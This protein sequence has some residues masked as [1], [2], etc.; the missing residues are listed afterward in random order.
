MICVYPANCTDFSTNGLGVVNPQSCIVTETLNGEW[1]L[2]LVHPIDETGKWQ[3]LME[4]CI[5]RAPVPA[6]MTPRVQISLPEH[7]D[8]QEIYVIDTDTSEA[9][10]RGGT[11]RLRVGPGTGYTTL[12]QY[13]NGT[14]LQVIVKTNA[15]WYEVVMPDGK[16][17]FMDTRFLR[18][19]RTEGSYS[20]AINTVVTA[21][22]LRDQPFRIY[23]V[24]PELNKVTIHA[25]HIFYDLLDNMVKKIEPS[26]SMAGAAVVQS[27]SS[28]CLSEHGFT[29]YSNLTST[30]EG[31]CIENVNPVEGILGESGLAQKYHGELAR[32]WFDVFLVDRVGCDSDVQIRERKNLLGVSY[33]IDETDVVTRIMPTGQDA[34]G[35]LLYLPE[36]YIDSPNIGL[37]THPK[38]IHLA[39]SEAKEVTEGD[40]TKSKSEC[41]AEMRKAVQAQYDAG[42]DLPSVTLKVEFINC[43]DTEEYKQ[44]AALTDIFL[45]DSVR[46][47][48]R[49]IGVEVSMRMTQY[50]YDCLVG[51]YTSITLGTVADTLEGATISARQLASGSIT[52]AKLALNSVG[53]GQLQSGS[54]GSL[55]IKNAAISSAHIQTAAITRAHIAQA[56]IETLNVNALT[57]VS[58]KIQELAAG[59]ITTDELYTSIAMIA[60]A[61]LTTANI[62]NAQIEWAQIESLAADIATISKAQI[63]SANIDAA[64]IDWASITTLSAAVASMVKADIETADIDWSH[65]KDLATDTAIITQGTAGELYIAKLAVTEANLVSLTV[66]E[67]VVKGEDGRFY[68]VSIDAEGNV[69]SALKQVSNED[70]ADVSIH[71]TQKLIEGSITA[72]T[73]NVQEIFADN[74]TVRSI[75]A[76]N[77]DVDTLFARE[78]TL[79]AI[80][81]MD[82]TGN[83]YLKLM[84]SGK[85]DQTAVDALGERVSAA[86]L[87]LTEDS[88]VSVVRGSQ[89][90][91]EDL[92]SVQTT[93]SGPEFIV[94]TQT[95]AVA[96]WTG[97]ASFSQLKD[98]QQITYWLPF[99]SSSSVTLELTLPDGSTTG[100]I[101]CYYSQATRITSQ[102]SGGNILHLT[103]REN[104]K[105]LTNTIEKGWWADANYNTDTYDRIR[106][107]SVKV[108]EAF[109]AFRF[110][111]ADSSGYFMLAAGKPFDISK[112]ILWATGTGTAGSVTANV[113]LAYSSIYLRY[114]VSGFTGVQGA[115]CYLAGALDGTMFTPAETYLTCTAPAA[116]DG[117]TY[118]LLGT[119]SS[120]YYLVLYPEHPMYRYVDGAFKP[121]SYVGYEARTEVEN[122]RVET[123]TAIEQT[124][125]SIALKADQTAVD[126]LSERMDSAEIKLQPD[127]IAS[128]VRSSTYYQNDLYHARNYALK[129]NIACKFIG[130]KYHNGSSQTNTVTITYNVS[131]DLFEHSHDG[132]SIRISVD[133]LRSEV[134]AASAS[135]A[136]VYSGMFLYFTYLDDSGAETVSG[137]GWYLRTTD[138][139]FR[140][141][142][143]TW[144]RITKG[145]LNIAAYNAIKINYMGLG[146][147][148]AS[149]STGTVQFRN[150]KL[151]VSNSFTP[152]S[153]APEDLS[154][155]QDRLTTAESSITQHSN[156]IALKV[157][158]S[159]YN[160]NR[161]YRGSTAPTTLYT[162][163]LWLDTSVSPNLLKRYT[164]STWVVAG[165][166]EV[167]SSGL[168]IGSNNVSI[169][170]ENFLLQLLDP[171]NNENV[172]MEMSA[173]GNVGF[174]ELYA[175]DIV[176]KSVVTAYNGPAYLYVD[177]TY[178][179]TDE[180]YCRTFNDAIK[181]INYK[182][183][184][185]DIAILFMGSE[186]ELYEVSGVQIVGICGHGQVIISGSGGYRLNTYMTIFGCSVPINFQT[187]SIR[188]SR[189]HST[190]TGY[191]IQL[192]HS[193]LVS[194]SS[195]TLDC[196]GNSY[197]ALFAQTTQTKLSYTGF[198]NAEYGYEVVEAMGSMVNCEGSCSWSLVAYSGIIFAAGTIPVGSQGII[199]NGQLFTSGCTTDSGMATS[200]STP[201]STTMQYATLTKSYRGGWR[202]DTNDVVQGLYSD[203][204]YSS[205]LPWNYGCM[206]F[207][208]LRSVLSG[209]TIRSATLTLHRKT[210]SGSGSA[211]NVYLCAISNTTNSG[212][213]S[214]VASFGSLGT[215]GRDEQVTFGIPTSIVTALANGTYG[216]LCLYE[217][218]YNFGSSTYSNRYIRI[219]G[220]DTSLRPYLTVVY[221]G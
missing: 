153:A 193:K 192:M 186:K 184:N 105:Y 129:S 157:S 113:Y 26:S 214:I 80:N 13:K 199:S 163:M 48:A 3:R 122:L 11:L 65:I 36:L 208:N 28:G 89:Q 84:V 130:G 118:I 107:G 133:I 148:H 135:T 202:T 9:S 205:S 176:S 155:V 180:H 4:G 137:L 18:Y 32:D 61:Q 209:Q 152:W 1:E 58:A 79:T 43:K 127:Q 33:D 85:A 67:L 66:G 215:I 50:S 154:D 183:L 204:G 132:A 171:S 162:N 37:Y 14:T 88:I 92:A 35:N 146:V 131:D 221:G 206:W 99:G 2:T 31:V 182:Y 196:N 143:D 25:R 52:G 119:L 190:P 112:P 97:V 72:Q 219:S 29:F 19:E 124:Q 167:K 147:S 96:A 194:F 101:P 15:S 125:A 191:L 53:S 158:T 201:L 149:G 17:G 91:K 73:L 174:K 103:Y 187:L 115:S 188:E 56:L 5:L 189:V 181:R 166:Q 136:G 10:V 211:K 63:T 76:A 68:S 173:D 141:T 168:Y 110:V 77:L 179:G 108:K 213:P 81:A 210:G 151:E 6:A 49:R 20:D 217:T 83:T 195:C 172:L 16:H 87:K 121:L 218:P 164:G 212:A 203:Y 116:E 71:G 145:P 82:I 161:V 38:W 177:P 94:G 126:D 140:A 109:S 30:A 150:L 175:D 111:V 114:Q 104:A 60:T 41:Y 98:G 23:R 128:A 102:Y 93:G 51:K 39:V 75:I 95:S 216:G 123:Q 200:T 165:A 22:Q 142:D 134:E 69:T 207:G 86:E 139:D 117:L 46:V 100:A 27:L 106:S 220:A 74:A 70:I 7:N 169:R 170:T 156:Q 78:A 59:S 54:V 198:Y 47:V 42:C 34:D 57:A 62:I 90:Y 45:G 24:V 144:V 8:L 44:Y 40:E 197:V 138:T 21:R 55:Q 159:T 120:A 64:N 178:T 185:Y 160:A 12:K